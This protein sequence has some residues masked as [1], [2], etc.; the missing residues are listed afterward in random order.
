MARQKIIEQINAGI[1]EETR[2]AGLSED[3]REREIALLQIK[4]KAAQQGVILT[5]QELANIEAQFAA[6]D[7]QSLIAAENARLAIVQQ[8]SAGIEEE[9]RLAGLTEAARERELAL[10]RVKQEASQ[11][12]IEL[13]A[14]ELANIEAQF[15]ARDRQ[16]LID[17]E[18][19]RVAVLQQISAGIEEEN[20]LAGLTEAARE[21]E[22]ALLRIKQDAAQQGVQLSAQELANIEAQLA[23]RDQQA[24]LD[25]EVARRAVIEQINAQLSEEVRLVGLTEN[26][27]EREVELLRI[28]QD[29]AQQG[30]ELT[31]QELN[32]IEAQLAARQRQAQLQRQAQFNVDVVEPSREG[33]R[34]AGYDDQEREVQA[35][36]AS[37]R[38]QAENS[39]LQLQQAEEERIRSNVEAMQQMEMLRATGQE[40]GSALGNAFVNAATGVGTLRQALAGLLQDLIR[41]AAQRAI[42]GPLANAFGGLFANLGGATDFGTTSGQASY[43]SGAASQTYRGN[44][45]PSA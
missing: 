18:A 40:V 22:I 30:V 13:T 5:E 44:T 17:A 20:R 39:G 27:R 4:Q 38:A 29:A 11:Q 9:N 42:L 35:A 45:L 21:R 31:Q 26:A 15:D 25:A 7:Q 34:M 23:A 10:L 19:A 12:G 33:L 1:A 16:A 14:Q 24:A 2:L 41:I 32:N 8:I 28:K 3:A 43:D 36:I 6:R 37:A